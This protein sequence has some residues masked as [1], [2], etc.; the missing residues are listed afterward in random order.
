MTI[1]WQM[2]CDH[3]DDGW[4]L[5]CTSKL[6]DEMVK[7]RDERKWEIQALRNAIYALAEAV[8]YESMNGEFTSKV[9]LQIQSALSD[10]NWVEAFMNEE[11]LVDTAVLS[12]EG[13]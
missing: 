4:C 12:G 13:P 8:E 10:R 2:N 1:P 3:M 9:T 7:Y 6:G 11:V 5:D